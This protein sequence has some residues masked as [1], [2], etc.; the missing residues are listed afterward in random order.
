MVERS[1][2][3]REPLLGGNQYLSVSICLNIWHDDITIAP[4]LHNFC[5]GCFSEWSQKKHSS[6]LCRCAPSVGL[7]CNLPEETHSCAIFR[8]SLG[9]K[10]NQQKR[11]RAFVSDEYDSEESDDN[12]GPRCPQCAY[13]H[14]SPPPSPMIVKLIEKEQLFLIVIMGLCYQLWHQQYL[15]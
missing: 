5:N 13:R 15:S 10:D 8:R 14:T 1:L 6:V 9:L 12:E 11:G 7:L 2:S 3:T 4:C